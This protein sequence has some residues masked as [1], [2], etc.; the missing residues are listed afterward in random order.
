MDNYGQQ[1]NELRC[2]QCGMRMAPGVK[3]CSV[4]GTPASAPAPN[5]AAAPGYNAAPGYAPAGNGA[6]P[7]VPT[8]Q[9]TPQANPLP[10]GQHVSK[11]EFRKSYA[12]EHLRK[13]IRN[14]AIFGY[15]LCGLLAVM[16]IFLNWLSLIDA[17]IYLALN[18][19]MHLGKS[20]GCAIAI[21]AYGV[22]GLVASLIASGSIG[23]WGWIIIGIVALNTFKKIDEEY[24]QAMAANAGPQY[25]YR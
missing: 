21:L 7:P 24:A 5:P 3:F 15:V 17:V 18:L 6:T 4:C 11:G 2:R 19:G 8:W 12:S 16:G 14:I 10:V 23:G 9:P 20:K 13:Q 22:V 25:G 1:T